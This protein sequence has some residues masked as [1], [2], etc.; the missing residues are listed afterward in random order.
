M[1]GWIRA[2]P[3]GAASLGGRGLVLAA[4]LGALLPS[5]AAAAPAILSVRLDELG[6]DGRLPISAAFC[7]PPQ[8]KPDE[9]NISPAIT[10]SPGPAGTMSYVLIMTDLDA[11]A[12]LSLMNKPGV[13]MGPDTPRVPFIH[14]VLVDIPAALTHLDRGEE[15]AGFVPGP[16]PL[17]PT[18]HGVRGANVYSG[19]YPKGS[20]LAGPR[21]GYDGPCP[22]KNDL[23]AHRYLTRVYALDI[24][25]LGL[26]GVFFGEAVQGRLAGHIL[27]VGE[28]EANYGPAL[29]TQK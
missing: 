26:T 23:K 3:E 22:P 10:W 1:A 8:M 18:D 13:V 21:G 29:A 15:S 25:T 28:V 2:R 14:W 7:A 24:K 20:S 4:I 19:F 6:K 12:D 5:E 27:A 11:P 16:R 9:H 17:G